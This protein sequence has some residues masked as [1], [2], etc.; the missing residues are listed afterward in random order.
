M[1]KTF[2]SAKRYCHRSIQ[3]YLLGLTWDTHGTKEVSCTLQHTACGWNDAFFDEGRNR[4]DKGCSVI[5]ACTA[6]FASLQLAEVLN[7][8]SGPSDSQGDVLAYLLNQSRLK[9]RDNARYFTQGH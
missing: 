3:H 2:T 4:V 1:S 7:T 5:N 6:D 9:K 8:R